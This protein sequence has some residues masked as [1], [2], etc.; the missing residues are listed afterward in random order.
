[1]K[2]LIAILFSSVCYG[3][4]VPLKEYIDMRFE[5]L[6]LKQEQVERIREENIKNAY[7]SMNIRL[8]GMNE[9]RQTLSDSNKTYVTWQSLLALVIGISGFLFGYS[10][11]KKN[12]EKGSIIRSGDNVEVKK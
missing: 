5:M 7:A 2:L 9:F 11:Y 4:D 12:Q 6:Q 1:M 8:D 3:Q 10:N